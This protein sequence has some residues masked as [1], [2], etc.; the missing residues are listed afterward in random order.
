[1]EDLSERLQA[2]AE[3]LAELGQARL[4]EA[5]SKTEDGDEAGAARAAARE[6][7]LAAAR[8]SVLKAVSALHGGEEGA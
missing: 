7:S 3:E 8:R 5:L 6:R 4:A 1:V 2:I